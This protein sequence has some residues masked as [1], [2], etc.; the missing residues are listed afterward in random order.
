MDRM[1][2][3]MNTIHRERFTPHSSLCPGKK[4]CSQ[5]MMTVKRHT[6]GLT[7]PPFSLFVLEPRRRA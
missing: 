7:K 4:Y 2:V 6:K 3:R 5:M 1:M